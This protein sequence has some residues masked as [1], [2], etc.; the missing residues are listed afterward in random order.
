[1]AQP[2]LLIGVRPCRHFRQPRTGGIADADALTE[3]EIA[4]VAELVL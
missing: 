1:L 3:K 4:I 2:R